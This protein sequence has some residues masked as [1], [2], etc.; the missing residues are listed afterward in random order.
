MAKRFLRKYR[1]IV[2]TPLS[3]YEG[4]VTQEA[5]SDPAERAQREL[6]FRQQEILSGRRD[7]NA[8]KIIEQKDRIRFETFYQNQRLAVDKFEVENFN[9]VV[10][11]DLHMTFNINKSDEGNQDGNEIV[12]YNISDSTRLLLQQNGKMLP[13]ITLQAGY[14]D[15]PELYTIFKGEIVAVS[16]NFEGTTR[17]TKL[18]VK[19]GYTNMKEAYTTRAY[20]K[21]VALETVVNDIIKD[22][23]LEYGTVFIPRVN[24]NAV[25]IDKNFY[26]MCTSED[27]LKRLCRENDLVTTVEDGKVNVVP[28]NPKIEDGDE[29]S[30]GFWSFERS[31]II[32]NIKSLL[33]NST[34][35]EQSTQAFDNTIS[36]ERK[37]YKVNREVSAIL[38]TTLGNIIGSPSIET[39]NEG[40]MQNQVGKP[41]TIKIKTF[42][43]GS[44]QLSK[45]VKVKS[46]F[47]DGIYIIEAIR[48]TGQYEG[49]EWYT[50]LKLKLTDSWVV[51]D[52]TKE[53][54]QKILADLNNQYINN[55]R[56]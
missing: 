1:I 39:N 24:D 34:R 19:S 54:N 44:F 51:D 38:D 10:I 52:R 47:V 9:G 37:G 28:K 11:E 53:T 2:G 45:P 33:N 41:D 50:E 30:S 6:F 42:L 8:Q 25:V 48:H 35:A 18:I 7:P 5:Y 12:L 43:D 22:M 27:G 13:S 56:G 4:G 32:K 17:V 23:K 36:P 40:V 31:F 20:K 29:S 49:S 16:D 55:T 46:K 3:F 21:G 15:D 26:L 14:Q